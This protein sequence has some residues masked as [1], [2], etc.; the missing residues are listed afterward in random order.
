ML[1]SK[2]KTLRSEVLGKHCNSS[3]IEFRKEHEKK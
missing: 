1:F 3:A 2:A